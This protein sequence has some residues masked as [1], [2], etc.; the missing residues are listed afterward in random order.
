[1]A[2]NVGN[3]GNDLVTLG[4]LQVE[5]FRLDLQEATRR[6]IAP[7]VVAVLGIAFVIGCCPLALF[8]LSWFLAANTSLS[9]A[10]A[11]L[12]VA[13]GGLVLAAILFALAYFWLRSSVAVLGRSREEFNRNLRWVKSLLT[14]G[15]R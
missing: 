1:M 8:G 14:Q 3:L 7:L 12:I 15:R 9:Q 6:S 4:E 13:G 10:A 2:G 11:A 5:L